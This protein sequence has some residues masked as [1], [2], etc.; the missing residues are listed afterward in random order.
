MARAALDNLKQAYKYRLHIKAMLVSF[1]GVT[2]SHRNPCG[3]RDKSKSH[4]Y[5]YD[6]FAKQ[7]KSSCFK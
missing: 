3:S 2:T 7:N 4:G 6:F 5:G 1:G